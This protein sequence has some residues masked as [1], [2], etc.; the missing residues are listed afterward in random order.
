VP[1]VR[2]VSTY[3]VGIVGLG[4]VGRAVARRLAPLGCSIAWTG[5]SAKADVTLSYVPDLLALARQSD[6]LILAAPLND[7]TR[8]MVDRTII[9]AVGSAGMIIN[10][11]RG[12]LIDEDALIAAYA[13]AGSARPRSTCSP[14]SRRRR[15]AGGTSPMSCSRPMPRG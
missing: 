6:A 2:S 8:G 3:A 5:P 11:G 9:D 12:D 15:T 1:P 10:V 7:R 4:A 14:R 13:A